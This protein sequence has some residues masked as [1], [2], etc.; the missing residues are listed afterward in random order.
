ML[1]SGQNKV[2]TYD[3]KLPPVM[4]VNKIQNILPHRYPFLLIDKIFHLD[5]QMVA[6]IK[7]VTM[8]EPFFQ[9]HFPGNP[10]MPGVLQVEAMA[11]IGGILENGIPGGHISDETGSTCTY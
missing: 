5:D 2:P 4:D 3:P 1:E 10:V 6:G 11:L 9:G 8:N 7:N